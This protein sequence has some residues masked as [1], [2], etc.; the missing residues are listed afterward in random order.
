MLTFDDLARATEAEAA[1]R[2]YRVTAR[3]PLTE[4]PDDAPMIR[5]EFSGDDGEIAIVI[6]EIMATRCRQS[7]DDFAAH[8][9]KFMR[10]SA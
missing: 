4:G 8:V 10:A 3:I 6:D 5:Y 7:L 2:G 9:G 1:R